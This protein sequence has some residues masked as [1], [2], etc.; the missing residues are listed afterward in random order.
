MRLLKSIK[1]SPKNY[2]Q[3]LN[4]TKIL[5]LLKL[6]ILVLGIIIGKNFLKK[7]VNMFGTNIF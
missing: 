7:Y 3:L 6:I 4:L 1:T 2:Y 5:L